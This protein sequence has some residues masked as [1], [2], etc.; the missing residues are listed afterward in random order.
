MGSSNRAAKSCFS[1]SGVSE[2]INVVA[3]PFCMLRVGVGTGSVG[4]GSERE[5]RRAR[6]GAGAEDGDSLV[7]TL[8]AVK[9]GS[10]RPGETHALDLL[11]G[12]FEPVQ[13]LGNGCV[14]AL[15]AAGASVTRTPPGQLTTTRTATTTAGHQTR[16]SRTLSS[17]SRAKAIF[18][19]V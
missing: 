8:S 9:T 17:S 12:I 4:M 5:E 3:T 11:D 15:A 7:Y 2:G 1:S 10:N 19:A 16:R 18:C 13:G 6:L 14:R